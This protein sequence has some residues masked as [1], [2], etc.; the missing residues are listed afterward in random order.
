MNHEISQP[1]TLARR[2]GLFDATMIVM[3]GIIGSGIFMNP[4]VV[5]QYIHTPFLILSAWLVGGIIAIAGS[6]VYAEL[7]ARK[8]EAG[9]EYVYLGD[10]IHPVVGFMYGWGL[11]FVVHTGGMAAVSLTFSRYFL[12]LTGLA[13]PD[14]LIAIVTLVILTTVNCLGVKEGS[15]LQSFFMILKIGAVLMLV[16]CGY[17][18]IDDSRFTMQPL[19]DR[20]PS[21]D[22]VS[23][24][25]AALVPLLFA[26]G[27]WQTTNFIA[28]EVENPG[29]N[30]P[31]GL[32][33]GTGTVVVLYI[34]VN[35][36]CLHALGADGLAQTKTPASAVMQLALG[37]T[38]ATLIGLGITISTLGFLSQSILTG[39]RVYYAMANDGVFFKKVGWV[40]PKTKAPVVAIV[41][42]GVAAIVIAL[43]GKYE[44][45][46]NYVVAADWVWFGLGGACIFVYRLRESRSGINHTGYKLPGHPYTT[47]IYT[48][49]CIAIVISTVYNFPFDSLI[50]LAII[51]T[52]IPLFYLWK[53]KRRN[54]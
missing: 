53:T 31:R 47:G 22:L 27:G 38:G 41:L 4:Y 10:A 19:L 52:G 36:V 33:I 37:N 7:A 32:L 16:I 43:S 24:F 29:K 18:L 49:A 1:Q 17:L 21:F 46:L 12:T 6:F 34:L 14:W 54:A 48:L 2:L 44:Q 3:G 23:G 45:I 5:A 39:P 20:P 9:G 13:L 50:G 25:G 11:L 15:N 8:P 28:G 26:Y 30:L 51:A 40:H 42:Q 35:Y